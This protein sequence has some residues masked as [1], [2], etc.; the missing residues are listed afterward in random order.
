MQK[1]YYSYDYIHSII[2]ENKDKLLK[3]N[4]E[5]IIAIGGGGYIPARIMR[6]NIKAT[7]LCV[8]IQLYH[9]GVKQDKPH[10]TQWLDE[11]AIKE[12]K[13]KRILIVDEVDDTRTTLHFVVNKMKEYDVADI[14]VYVLHNKLK[15]KEPLQIKEENYFYGLQVKEDTWIVYPWEAD[16]IQKHNEETIPMLEKVDPNEDINK[17]SR[18]LR[19]YLQLKKYWELCQISECQNVEEDPMS[20]K[21]ETNFLE[22]GAKTQTY[23]DNKPISNKNESDHPDD[24]MD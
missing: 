5:V 22:Y 10:I 20:K 18:L 21:M 8:G 9:N 2:R 23:F 13:G 4:P 7:I 16:D 19:E 24:Q 3:Y 6:E 15:K 1:E 14:G 12:I 17:M 11:Y